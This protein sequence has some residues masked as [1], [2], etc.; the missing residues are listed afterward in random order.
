MAVPKGTPYFAGAVG[1]VNTCTAQG[2]ISVVFVLAVPTY[3][4]S[5][6]LQAFL[7]LKNNYNEDKYRWIEVPVHIIAYLIGSVYA[8][9][10][11]ATDNFNPNGSGC[12]YAKAPWGCESDPAVPCERGEDIGNLAIIMQLTAI[13]L[14]FIFPPSVVISIYCWMKKKQKESSRRNSIGMTIIRENARKEMMHSAYLQISLYLFSFWFTYIPTLISHICTL[15][16][17]TYQ[18]MTG[19]HIFNFYII[20]N[21]VY[22]VQGFVFMMVYFT[23]QRM[24]KEKAENIQISG[25]LPSR[26]LSRQL[27][28]EDIRKNAEEKNVRDTAESDDNEEERESFK[29]NI[30]DGEPDEDSPWA[31]FIDP[32]GTSDDD[33]EISV[34]KQ[35]VQNEAAK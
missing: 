21:C 30:F 32:D 24:G 26:G 3:Y 5:L 23:L 8:I 33:D 34:G 12:W 35:S 16:H 27:T 15:I 13:C 14:Y 22:A 17:Q 7:G 19:E 20:A 9:I 1:T 25:K 29:F 2:F 31:R 18:I 6:A 28:V 4:G 11:A 10:T